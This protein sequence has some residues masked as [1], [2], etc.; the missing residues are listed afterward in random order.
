MRLELEAYTCRVLLDWREIVDDGVQPW[1]LLA[2]RLGGRGVPSLDEAMGLIQ[3]EP[4]HA[5]LRAIL[6]PAL[7]GALVARAHEATPEPTLTLADASD[8][9][10]ALLVEARTLSKRSPEI[11]GDEFL[12]D[13][14]GAVRAFE[15]R[16]DAA[17]KLE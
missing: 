1:T 11:T 8:L 15:A 12:G 7:V 6:D 4:V 14:D 2:E 9:V 3:L 5:A 10:R 13:V 16:L 17:L